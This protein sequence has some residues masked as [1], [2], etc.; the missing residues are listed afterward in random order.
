[1]YAVFINIEKFY[2]KEYENFPT[3][4]VYHNDKVI[5]EMLPIEYKWEYKGDKKEY[6]LEEEIENYEF[7]ENN[8]ALVGIHRND[9]YL[10]KTNIRYKIQ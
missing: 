3:I 10:C 8:T 1:M 5:A 4:S 9:E 7:P 6:T 2:Q